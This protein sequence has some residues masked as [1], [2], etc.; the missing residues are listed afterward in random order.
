MP[1]PR[2]NSPG[3]Y[4]QSYTSPNGGDGEDQADQPWLRITEVVATD[5]PIPS[6]SVWL[7]LYRELLLRL[8]QTEARFALAVTF[9][10][11]KTLKSAQGGLSNLFKNRLGKEA[12]YVK[13]G[14]TDDGTPVL[15][16]RRGENW[17]RRHSLSGK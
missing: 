2:K 6:K 10:D 15:Y 13:A 7:P 17:E 3:E 1:R 14:H 8:E 5:V 9:P 12:V 4:V 11:D 16:I